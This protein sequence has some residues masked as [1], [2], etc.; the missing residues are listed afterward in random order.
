M[1]RKKKI[2]LRYGKILP[3]CNFS[4]PLPR[5]KHKHIL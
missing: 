4:I 1:V 3:R 5:L 2:L